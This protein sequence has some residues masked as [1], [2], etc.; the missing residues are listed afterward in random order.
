MRLTL[1]KVRYF[2]TQ[3]NLRHRLITRWAIT[4]LFIA[5]TFSTSAISRH[6]DTPC[7][8]LNAPAP[9]QCT[10]VLLNGS[11]NKL[12]LSN[13]KRAK[14][15]ISPFSTFKIPNS[16]IAF[17]LD[18][19]NGTSAPIHYDPSNYPSESWWPQKWHD[20]TH[21]IKDAFKY[22]VVPIYR[23]IATKIGHEPMQ[24]MLNLFNYGNKNISS[25]LDNFWL[26]KSM[27]ISA[28]EQV[29]FLQNI[30]R[31]TYP[32]KST[33]YQQLAEIMLVESTDDYQ[34]YAKTGGGQIQEDK[35]QGWYV[36]YVVKKEATYYFAVNM[37]GNTFKYVQRKRIEVAK[38]ALVETGVL[39]QS[40]LPGY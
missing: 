23:T 11:T 38:S 26:D 21:N 24:S 40:A 25:G 27:K 37:D 33:S 36:G 4:S 12:I 7:E 29:K 35:A 5:L 9:E 3:N 34:I 28:I 32:L 8:Q 22:S 17:E 6:I 16:L 39:P 1:L 13:K 2:F 15:R 20:T 14:I 10:F 19:V 31:Q 30:H 18:I